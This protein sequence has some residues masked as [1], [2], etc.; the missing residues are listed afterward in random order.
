MDYLDEFGVIDERRLSVR[1]KTPPKLKPCSQ[2]K[3]AVFFENNWNG[4]VFRPFP[5]ES[6]AGQTGQPAI[7]HLQH[8][9]IGGLA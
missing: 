5:P 9:S 3:V 8:F 6:A 4:A 7:T 1:S 2:K